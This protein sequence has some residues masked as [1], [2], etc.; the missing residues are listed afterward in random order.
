MLRTS[1]PRP[2]CTS[3]DVG[4][5]RRTSSLANVVLPE[6]V[7]P[8]TAT[9]RPGGQP[10]V[11]VTED[12]RTA[13]IGVPPTSESATSS[14]PSGRSTPRWALPPGLG[15][16]GGGVQH[17]QDPAP[18]GHGVLRLV[19][20]LDAD[21]H[22]R[23]EQGDEEEEGQYLPRAHLSGKTEADTDQHDDV[24]FHRPQARFTRPGAQ[25]PPSAG[26]ATHRRGVVR[27]DRTRR[28]EQPCAPCTP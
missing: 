9:R 4:S 3:P 24:R 25:A 28:C 22:G 16:I 19:E 18:P 6:P 14:R 20:H 12:G 1:A 7:S 13:R 8:T 17:R 27:V 10:Y 2:R 15:N 5:I 23:D 21:L 11:D 26:L